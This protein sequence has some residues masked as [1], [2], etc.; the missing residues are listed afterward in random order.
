LPGYYEF[1]LGQSLSLFLSLSS[2]A[3]TVSAANFSKFRGSP[4]Q[5]FHMDRRPETKQVIEGKL[6]RFRSG[7]VRDRVR[8]NWSPIWTYQFSR[9]L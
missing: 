2:L 7:R 5:I 4:R 3:T 6:D 9:L 8:Y 1:Y